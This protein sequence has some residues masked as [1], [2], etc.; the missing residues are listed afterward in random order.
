MQIELLPQEDYV[1]AYVLRD[2]NPNH[3]D[4]C[5][6]RPVPPEKRSF[7]PPTDRELRK[8]QERFDKDKDRLFDRRI[9]TVS[10]YKGCR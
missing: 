5:W 4:N 6:L 7:A 10:S 2:H 9:V 8:R 3:P 1:K